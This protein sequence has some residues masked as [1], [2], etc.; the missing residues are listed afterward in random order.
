MNTQTEKPN[1]GATMGSAESKAREALDAGAESGRRAMDEA[2]DAVS[3]GVHTAQQKLG[4]TVDRAKEAASNVAD[5]VSN[6]ANYVGQKAEDATC[7]VGETLEN[8]GHYL[9]EEGL[10]HMA[11][12]MSNMIRRN[13]IPAMVLGVGLGYLLAQA[14]ARRNA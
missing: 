8:T 2:K 4:E 10:Q 11:S 12:D 7:R 3:T 1:T 14:C 5:S 9:K 13:P 6:A